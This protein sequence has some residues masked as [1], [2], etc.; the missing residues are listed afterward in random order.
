MQGSPQ[1]ILGLFFS[2]SPFRHTHFF[3]IHRC[4]K[5]SCPAALLISRQ[6]YLLCIYLFLI[7][8]WAQV[9]PSQWTP[10]DSR[11]PSASLTPPPSIELP[12]ATVYC[13]MYI[14]LLSL[15]ESQCAFWEEISTHIFA[16]PRVLRGRALCIVDIQILVDWLIYWHILSSLQKGPVVNHKV[17]F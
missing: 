6:K 2:L 13:H 3:T 14:C 1:S 15:V 17:L 12:G 9:P 16:L 11:R 7:G 8:S 4:L 10:S 5:H